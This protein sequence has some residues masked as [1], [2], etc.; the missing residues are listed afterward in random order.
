VKFLD[1]DEAYVLEAAAGA[2]TGERV[3]T[4]VVHRLVQR[5]L[6]AYASQPSSVGDDGSLF[7]VINMTPP[8]WMLLSLYRAGV[9]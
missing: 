5:G 1:A 2:G 4:V 7:Y 8:A 3:D 9:R 6:L